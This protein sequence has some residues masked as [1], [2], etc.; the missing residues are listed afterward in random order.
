MLEAVFL[1]VRMEW[2]IH[3][4]A[5]NIRADNETAFQYRCQ[6][7]SMFKTI[8]YVVTYITHAWGGAYRCAEKARRK[9]VVINL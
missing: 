8:H 1:C 3:L 7:F 5:T 9:K 6:D 4:I 2:C